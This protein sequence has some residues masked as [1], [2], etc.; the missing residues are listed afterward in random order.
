MRL[1]QVTT[2]DIEP[3]LLTSHGINDSRI[4]APDDRH[5]VVH[6]DIGRLCLSNKYSP[7]PLTISSG[8]S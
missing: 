7:S 3:G 1:A 5:V 6:V 2:V 4:A 8:M